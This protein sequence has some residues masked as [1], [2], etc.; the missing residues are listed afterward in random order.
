MLTILGGERWRPPRRFAVPAA[1]AVP[2][3]KTG[4]REFW[5]A[6]LID[7]PRGLAVE[8]FARDGSGLISGLSSAGGL[9]DVA[10]DT[11]AIAEGDLVQFIPYGEF[12]L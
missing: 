11:L 9:I 6:A 7:T 12:G 1:F 5:R 2:S 8:K 3:R 10:E 4:R